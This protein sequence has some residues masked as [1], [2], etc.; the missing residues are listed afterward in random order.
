MRL[1]RLDDVPVD[2]RGSFG[3]D[4]QDGDDAHEADNE[5]TDDRRRLHEVVHVPRG[6]ALIDNDKVGR[7]RESGDGA[8]S[9]GKVCSGDLQLAVPANVGE[10]TRLPE[11]NRERL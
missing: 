9:Q 1:S 6:A 11:V 10:R 7:Y 4:L 8:Q 2:S 5:E 3:Q